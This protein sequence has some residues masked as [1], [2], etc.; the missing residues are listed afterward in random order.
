MPNA[1]NVAV[2]IGSL[3][4]DSI[5]RKVANALAEVAP[6]TLRLFDAR[7]R[8]LMRQVNEYLRERRKALKEL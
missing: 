4:R 3:R 1:R 2:I 5:N 8:A 6:A 7:S